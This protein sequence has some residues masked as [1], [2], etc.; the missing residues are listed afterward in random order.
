MF[1]GESKTL[2]ELA[3]SLRTELSAI[4]KISSE[5]ISAIRDAGNAA[6]EAQEDIKQAI[7][8]LQTPEA[9]RVHARTYRRNNFIVQVILTVG[10]WLAFIA[11]AIYAGIA[12]RQ[13][14]IM[15]QTY[16]QIQKQ[17]TLMRQQMVGTQAATLET[18]LTFVP[19]GEFTINV[20]N[21]GLVSAIDV[22]IHGQAQR[23]RD[24]VRIGESFPLDETLPIV[25]PK[26][27]QSP[28]WLLPWHPR[29]AYPQV[30]PA[31]WPGRET[32]SFQGEIT[33]Q[34][35]F[36]DEIRDTFCWKWLPFYF[37]Q[38]RVGGYS[39]GGGN[40]LVPCRNFDQRVRA[41]LEAEKQAENGADRPNPPL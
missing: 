39:T 1:F 8:T 41:T 19:S 22:H 28:S 5:Q 11:A 30:W 24:G 33:Y 4:R 26:Q 25:A 21:D 36:G 23:L 10:T 18:L 12:A 14:T 9:D 20:I 13:A 29:V 2:K 6:E 37:I 7:S 40:L 3:D 38:F 15:N 31:G 35:G 17:T 32:F 16:G 34:N 27:R